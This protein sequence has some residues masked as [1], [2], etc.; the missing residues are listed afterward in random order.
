MIA[1]GW[2]GKDFGIFVGVN[3]KI[4]QGNRILCLQFMVE[5]ASRPLTVACDR[6]NAP[7]DPLGRRRAGRPSHQDY[8]RT[9]MRLP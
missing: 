4:R 5:R 9:R 8:S 6:F 1:T 2:D 7:F 3:E